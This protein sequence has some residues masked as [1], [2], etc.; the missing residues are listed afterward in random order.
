M[1]R[2]VLLT[3]ILGTLILSVV[4]AGLEKR[5]QKRISR[6]ETCLQK[7]YTARFIDSCKGE[8]TADTNLKKRFR[9]T[10]KRI[11]KSVAQRCEF[12]C[13]TEEQEGRL[14]I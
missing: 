14:L 6:L 5:C 13:E 12:Q 7:G 8:G 10:C 9:R 1:V 2:A 4:D 3:L 11:E